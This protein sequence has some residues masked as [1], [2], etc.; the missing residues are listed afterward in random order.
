MPIA[1]RDPKPTIPNLGMMLPTERNVWINLRS[2]VRWVS[3]MKPVGQAL[4]RQ[5]FCGIVLRKR[6]L[7]AIFNR[8]SCRTQTSRC[9]CQTRNPAR[10]DRKFG[11]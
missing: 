2:M 6:F 7:R 4:W 11:D 8:T 5:N 3:M 9:S 1:C 10:V